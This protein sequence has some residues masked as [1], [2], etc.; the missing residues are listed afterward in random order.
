MGTWCGRALLLMLATLAAQCQRNP[1]VSFEI[2]LPSAVDGQ[3]Q[4][5]EVGVLPG[6]CPSPVELGGGIPATGAVVRVAFQ[7]ND[8]DPPAI[9]AL[10]K[11]SY[12]F[13]AAAR[14]SDCSVLAT[15]CTEADVTAARDIVITMDAVSAPAGACAAGETCAAGRCAPSTNPDDPGIGAGCSMELIGAGPFGVPLNDSGDIASA[16]AVAVTETGFLF[17]YREYDPTQGNARLTVGAIDEGAALTV[18]TATLLPQQ[19]P[20]QDETDA[21]GLA[22]LGGTGVVVSARPACGASSGLDVLAVDDGG[23]VGMSTFNP[24]NAAAL[25]NAHAVSLTSASAGWLAFVHQGAA[26][27]I[28]LSGL[29]TQGNPVSFGGASSQTMAEVSATSTMLALLSGDGTSLGVKLSASLVAS[30][31]AGGA[32]L[33]TPGTWGA[34][35]ADASRAYVLSDGGSSSQPLA[36]AAYDLGGGTAAASGSFAPPGQG[37]VA[38]GDVAFHADRAMFA[39]EQPGAISV[40]VYDHASTTPTP[41]RSVLFSNDARI[42]SQLGVRD[43]RL[44]IAASDSR[45]LVV[46]MT[47]TSLGPDDPVGGYAVYACSP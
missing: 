30:G 35:A 20:G 9:G 37:T 26:D 29:L 2:V 11:A 40:V 15:G 4:W 41:L 45:V 28:G 42:P 39:V 31:D 27:A 3:V 34:I 6:A 38:G 17:A 8:L 16:P 36:F 25:S 23:N 22:Y 44:A 5:V 18:P 46:W 14:G 1:N 21:I 47:A 32:A 12:A 10:K 13:A 19:C 24:S 7:T 43:G 33:T